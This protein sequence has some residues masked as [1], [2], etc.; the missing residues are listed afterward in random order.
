MRT[1]VDVERLVLPVKSAPTD[2]ASC[3]VNQVLQTA[4]AP[5]WICKPTSVTVER[6]AAPVL[7][8]V[9]VPKVPAS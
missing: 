4:P 2:N 1:V 7:L 5:V 3:R 8:A 6:A 9:F